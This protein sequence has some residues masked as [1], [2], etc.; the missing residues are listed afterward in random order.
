MFPRDGHQ[1]IFTQACVIQGFD[2]HDPFKQIPPLLME[3]TQEHLPH[4]ALAGAMTQQ[5]HRI[6]FSHGSRDASQILGVDR[7]ALAG[8]ITIMAMGEILSGPP[9]AVGTKHRM[10][11]LLALQAV[12]IGVAMV[13]M[14]HQTMAL[15]TAWRYLIR[16]GMVGCDAGILE[17]MAH[18]HH[19]ISIEVGL[20]NAAA[21]ADPRLGSVGHVNAEAAVIQFGD[22]GAEGTEQC[23]HLRTADAVLQRVSEQRLQR[24]EMVFFHGPNGFSVLTLS[25]PT[26][27]KLRP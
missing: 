8:Q 5:Q 12:D 3:M 19:R 10:L 27:G 18:P 16:L 7:S 20:S 21:G 11:H 17:E 1:S 14:Q 15:I 6:R 24:S 23:L 9:D 2:A 26:G 25:S 22:F 13:E 4:I